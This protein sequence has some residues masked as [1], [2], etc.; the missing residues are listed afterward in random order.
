MVK[1]FHETIY[2]EVGKYHSP[3]TIKIW[4]AFFLK[5]FKNTTGL[6]Q[7]KQAKNWDQMFELEKSF[8][9]KLKVHSMRAFVWVTQLIACNP[10]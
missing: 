5:A 9:F 3:E 10:R 6:E 8:Y 1:L 2:F 4:A 7:L